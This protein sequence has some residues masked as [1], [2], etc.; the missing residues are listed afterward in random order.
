MSVRELIETYRR[1]LRDEDVPPLRGAELLQKLTALLGNVL[2]EIRTSEAAFNLVLLAFLDS[3]E[4][5][6]RAQIRAKTTTEYARAREAQDTQ[7]LLMELIR[8]LKI[9]LRVQQDEMKMAG[10]VR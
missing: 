10:H 6:N 9:I 8:S 4:A 1:E 5:A 7:K 2:E 3:D